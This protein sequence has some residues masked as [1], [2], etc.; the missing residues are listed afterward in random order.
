MA[1]STIIYVTGVN[2]YPTKGVVTGTTTKTGTFSTNGLIVIGVGSLFGTEVQRGDWLYS[3][4]NNEVRQVVSIYDTLGAGLSKAF[5]NNESAQAV[6]V[7]ND[8]GI[9]SAYMQD[10]STGVSLTFF[11]VF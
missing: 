10:T 3:T 9:Q 4:T 1:T 6:K 7:C 11:C 5:T 2:G 8:W